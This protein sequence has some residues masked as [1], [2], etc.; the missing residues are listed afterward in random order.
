MRGSAVTFAEKFVREGC[1][2]QF[3]V[4]FCSDM[5]NLAEFKSLAGIADD[6]TTIVYFHEN[7]LT[8]PVRSENSRDHQ[9]VFT[10]MTSALAA[11]YVWFNSEYNKSSFLGALKPFLKRMPDYQPL[12]APDA[13][14]DKSYVCPLGIEKIDTAGESEK[15]ESPLRILWAARWEYDKNPDDFF[16]A[17]EKL[18]REGVDFIVDVIGERFRNYPEIFDKAKRRFASRIDR[19]GYQES[20]NE[21]VQVLREAD[22]FVSTAN[23]EFFGLSALEAAAGGTAVVLPDRLAYPEVFEKDGK[24]REFFYDGS[25]DGLV[26]K[27][28]GITKL[29][30]E[31]SLKRLK[32]KALDIASRYF[33]ENRAEKLDNMIGGVND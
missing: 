18:E 6:V 8:Y 1:R 12:W 9:C 30:R 21:Y 26:E 5:L 14:K 11:D 16:G 4:I 25:V 24:G 29:K 32:R 28:K 3:D 13:I 23:H 7:Q 33:W 10:N 20:R 27:L 17:L 2:G 22:V 15:P 31:D 19:W